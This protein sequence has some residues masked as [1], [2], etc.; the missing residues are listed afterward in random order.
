LLEFFDTSVF[1]IV[2]GGDIHAK[3][4]SCLLIT[5]PPTHDQSNRR[6]L[7]VRQASQGCLEPPGVDPG[8]ARA[9][10]F[11][12]RSPI[13]RHAEPPPFFRSEPTCILSADRL[14]RPSR[15]PLLVISL[16]DEVL[17]YSKEITHGDLARFEIFEAEETKEHF[18]D[19]VLGTFGPDQAANEGSK[20]SVMPLV[21]RTNHRPSGFWNPCGTSTAGRCIGRPH[22]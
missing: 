14:E 22:G 4:H 9:P 8:D 10:D 5:Q 2:D 13:G 17:T 3:S 19:H 21:E 7:V 15:T 16:A 11:H 12:F 1:P 20:G 6:L 18:L